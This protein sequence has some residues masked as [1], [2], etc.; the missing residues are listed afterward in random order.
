MQTSVTRKGRDLGQFADGDLA[1][2][3]QGMQLPEAAVLVVLPSVFADNQS[4]ERSL[5]LNTHVVIAPNNR[6]DGLS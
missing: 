5:T 3:G 4:G 6:S 2:L 1:V